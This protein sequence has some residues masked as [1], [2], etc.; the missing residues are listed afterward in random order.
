[1]SHVGNASKAPH[2]HD[3]AMG[4]AFRSSSKLW[5]FRFS[6]KRLMCLEDHLLTAADYIA[7]FPGG[8]G[9]G[10]LRCSFWFQ[11]AMFLGLGRNARTGI[12]RPPWKSLRMSDIRWLGVMLSIIS[13]NGCSTMSCEML[14]PKVG[15]TE[16]KAPTCF[17][18]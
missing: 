18:Q 16:E 7:L 10:P 17:E 13:S 2:W 14:W 4:G 11:L 12:S 3:T 8:I 5:D 15:P 9:F 6:G 1:M